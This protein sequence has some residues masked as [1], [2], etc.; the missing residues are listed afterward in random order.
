MV[1]VDIHGMA[2]NHLR[3]FR[4]LDALALDDLNVVE[5]AENLMLD[6][7]LGAHGKLGTF[8]DLEG[9]VLEA[10]LAAWRGEVNRDGWA[11]RR[12]HGE[13]EDDADARVV[14]VGD[15]LAVT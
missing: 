6:L 13:G 14:G 1:V 12:V 7:E 10:L 15:V 8:L 5:A 9:L 2:Y 4:D 11:A 3:V